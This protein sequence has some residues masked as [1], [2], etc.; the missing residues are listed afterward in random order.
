M[1]RAFVHV[2]YLPRELPEHKVERDLLTSVRQ[3]AQ[4]S[5]GPASQ[6]QGL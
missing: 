1:E 4:A 5:S 3:R 6:D 2:D